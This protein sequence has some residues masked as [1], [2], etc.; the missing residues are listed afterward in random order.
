MLVPLLLGAVQLNHP[1]GFTAEVFAGLRSVVDDWLTLHLLQL[2]LVGLMGLA[3]LLLTAGLTGWPAALS[4]AAA[5]VFVVFST[6]A[7][8]VSGLSVGT[9]IQQARWLPTEEQAAVGAAVQ[10]LY[11]DPLVG[12]ALSV[13]GILGAIGWLVA[14][15]AAAAALYRAGAGLWSVGLL[16]A[17]GVLVAVSQ[18]PPFGPLGMLSFALAGFLLEWRPLAAPAW[19]APGA[20]N[21]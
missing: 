8:A 18:A 5:G 11:F 20:L 6:A 16:T 2:P 14:M 7:D 1:T 3:V 21:G 15:L 12:G 17:S 4:R 19:E 13:V 10:R 9:V